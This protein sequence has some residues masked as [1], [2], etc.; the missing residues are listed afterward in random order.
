MWLH[1]LQQQVEEIS[2][3]LDMSPQGLTSSGFK[4]LLL[5]SLWICHEMM[6]TLCNGWMVKYEFEKSD[7]MS[8]YIAKVIDF[9]VPVWE[10][11]WSYFD[12]AT[13]RLWLWLCINVTCDEW[14]F[15]LLLTKNE[16]HIWKLINNMYNWRFDISLEKGAL[17]YRDTHRDISVTHPPQG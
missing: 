5:G 16:N 8:H 10:F 1:M 17:L 12:Y 6:Y 7:L 11:G 2:Q 3:W 13:P 14:T 15:E 4:A 9:F